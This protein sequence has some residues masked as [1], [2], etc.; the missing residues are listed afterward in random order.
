MLRRGLLRASTHLAR[1]Q[2]AASARAFAAAAEE[3][4]GCNLLRLSSRNS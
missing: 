2:G 4:V 3:K 1:A